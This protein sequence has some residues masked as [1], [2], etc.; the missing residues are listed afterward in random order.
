MFMSKSESLTSQADDLAWSEVFEL[1]K[2][3]LKIPF[4]L[5]CVEIFYWFITQPSDTLVP[6]QISEAWIWN[7]LTNMIYGEGTATLSTHNGWMTRVDLYNSNFPG[8]TD[9]VALY[10]SDECAGI[11]EMIFIST[12]I[13]MTDGV[14]QKL[15]FR[16]VAVMCGI[17]YVLNIVRL[18]VFYPIAA[19][20]CALDP[21]NPLCLTG[22]WNYHEAIYKWG[23][24]LVLIL[25]WLVWFRYVG[26]SSKIINSKTN[27]EKWRVKIRTNWE[28]K[29][30]LIIGFVVIMLCYGAL[31]I[32]SNE[33]AMNAKETLEFCSFSQLSSNNSCIEA[34]NTWD[35]AINTSWSLCSIG[36]LIG[37]FTIFKYERKTE[38]GIWPSESNLE[39][40]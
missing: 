11:H 19:S 8:V 23:F 17:V 18:V 40:E 20:D 22:M 6:I 14:P 35:N 12:L 36:V 13:L 4:A 31:S 34:Q 30:F 33:T 15:K 25:M 39:E 24:L 10:V 26:G 38:D 37:A 29:H 7:E 28:N 27:K 2:K 16:S 5:L 21:N 32:T 1:G 3:Y 9:T